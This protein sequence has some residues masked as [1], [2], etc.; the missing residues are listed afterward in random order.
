MSCDEAFASKPTRTPKTHSSCWGTPTNAFRRT[1]ELYSWQSH[2]AEVRTM[3]HSQQ[4]RQA[5]DLS[6]LLAENQR[7]ELWNRV[8]GY[9][10]SNR[11]PSTSQ[12]NSP[13]CHDIIS[14]LKT[15]I[16]MFFNFFAILLNKTKW[17]LRFAIAIVITRLYSYQSSLGYI[18][19]ECP[20]HLSQMLSRKV[21]RLGQLS[22]EELCPQ[23]PFDQRDCCPFV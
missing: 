21:N 9:T 10:I 18:Q 6:F 20:Y 19:Q 7:F 8:T 3:I 13:Y 16:K 15:K 22:D 17:P 14:H 12:A 4:K 23:I 11:A 5:Q 1:C 2:E